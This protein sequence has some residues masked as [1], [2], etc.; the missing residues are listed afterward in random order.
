M[1]AV[2]NPPSLAGSAAMS[3]NPTI[4]ANI[5]E[6]KLIWLVA[7]RSRFIESVKALAVV[8]PTKNAHRIVIWSH[9]ECFN[10]FRPV[11]SPSIWHIRN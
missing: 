3:K 4:E 9:Q 8:P 7:G 11:E 6:M 10:I 5:V 2:K 1:N